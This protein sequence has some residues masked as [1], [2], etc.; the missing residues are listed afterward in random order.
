LLRVQEPFTCE[1][2]GEA[3]GVHQVRRR[4]RQICSRFR[5]RIDPKPH[6]IDRRGD[7][8]EVGHDSQVFS[9]KVAALVVGDNPDGA[10]DLAVDAERK[11]QAFLDARL[12]RLEVREM[13]LGPLEQLWRSPIQHDA[14]GTE[15]LGCSAAG[16][17]S[18]ASDDA[19]PLEAL[20]LVVQ[21]AQAC[22]LRAAHLQG[23]R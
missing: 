7:H 6:L 4:L 17:L 16:V 5:Q 14:T 12:H 11:Q 13:A 9:I 1:L 18:P 20:A 23:C 8:R 22:G 2:L 10:D 19:R 3:V 15:L 21:E